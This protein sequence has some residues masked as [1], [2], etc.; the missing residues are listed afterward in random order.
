MAV[1]LVLLGL[2]HFSRMQLAVFFAAIAGCAAVA[3]LSSPYLQHRLVEIRQDLASD[4]NADTSTG[5]RLYFWRKSVDFINE[6]PVLGHGTGSMRD[7]FRRNSPHPAQEAASNPHNQIF[8]VG[9]QLGV[10]GIL[11]LAA[12]WGVPWWL[13]T[14]AGFAEWVGLVIVAQNVVGSLFNSHLFDFTQGWL[15]VIGVGVAGGMVLRRRL[16]T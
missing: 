15:Y 2:R 1:V 6:A 8:A 9:I 13:L 5:A 10:I 7:T 16:K 14:G 4:R 12:M 3:W 11:A